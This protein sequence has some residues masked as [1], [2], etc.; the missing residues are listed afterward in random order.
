[1]LRGDFGVSYTYRV[2]VG[3]LIAERLQV[4]LPLAIYALVLA[5]AVAFPVGF[6]AAARRGRASDSALTAFM[7]LGLAVPNFWLG[8]AAGDGRSRSA[9]T[10]PP[11]ADFRGGTRDS[12]RR[13]AR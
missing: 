4:S 7:Q 10:S 3:S 11:P 12:G 1:M 5:A 13:C 2:P 9:C 8:H 6:A